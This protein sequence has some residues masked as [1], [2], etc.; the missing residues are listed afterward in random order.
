MGTDQKRNTEWAALLEEQ[1]KKLEFFL[2]WF[3]NY[4]V[5]V[6]FGY[7]LGSLSLVQ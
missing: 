7:H 2:W 4:R 1:L 3:Y 5:R 6:D